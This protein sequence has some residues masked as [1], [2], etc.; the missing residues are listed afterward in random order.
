MRSSELREQFLR[1]LNGDCLP[2][3]HFD[4]VAGQI[5]APPSSARQRMLIS[6]I[7]WLIDEGLIVVGGIVGGSDD[8]RVDPWDLSL[9]DAMARIYDDYVVHHDP[10]DWVFRIWFALTDRGQKK[11]KPLKPKSRRAEEP[12]DLSGVADGART[13]DIQDHNLVLYQLNYSHHRRTAKRHQRRRK[14]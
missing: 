7:R 12:S 9:D 4:Y 2:L 11:P 1:D 3:C 13:R 6:T 10:R 5:L 14:S 8:E